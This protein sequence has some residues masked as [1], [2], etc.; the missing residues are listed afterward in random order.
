MTKV[1]EFT[2]EDTEYTEVPFLLCALC[3]LCELR[4][5]FRQFWIFESPQ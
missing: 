2:T 1:S 3:A 5:N 4:V